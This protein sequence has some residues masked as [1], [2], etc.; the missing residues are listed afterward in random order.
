MRFEANR[1]GPRTTALLIAVQVLVDAGPKARGVADA[2]RALAARLEPL[3]DDAEAASGY[4]HMLG[5]DPRA[6]RSTTACS[7]TSPAAAFRRPP[8]VTWKAELG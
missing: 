3:L 1:Y 6:P 8:E 2:G 5:A 7:R 4:A